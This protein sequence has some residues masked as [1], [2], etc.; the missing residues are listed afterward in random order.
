MKAE[1]AE[2]YAYRAL[3]YLVRQA[4]RSDTI[5]YG[6]LGSKIGLNAQG[7]GDPLNYV[8]DEV[9]MPRG[10]PRLNIIV[11]R[12]DRKKRPPDEAIEESGMRPGETHQAAFARLKGEVFAYKGWDDLLSELGLTASD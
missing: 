5:Y 7:L 8:R 4:K 2:K 9:C 10:L 6:R 1:T 11:V 3:P 12:N